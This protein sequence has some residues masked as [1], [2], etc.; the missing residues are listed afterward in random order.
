MSDI[1]VLPIGDTIEHLEL[2]QCWCRPTVDDNA[3]DAVVVHHSADGRE[4][5]EPGFTPGSQPS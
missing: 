4:Y 3:P 1:H 5:Y 2:R